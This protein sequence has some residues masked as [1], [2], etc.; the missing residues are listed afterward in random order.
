MLQSL[1]LAGPAVQFDAD[2]FGQAPGSAFWTRQ[3]GQFTVASRQRD[4][5]ADVTA[6]MHVVDAPRPAQLWLHVGDVGDSKLVRLANTIGYMRARHVSQGNAQFLH[7]LT[8]QL[9]VPPERAMEVAQR[10]INARLVSP[11]GGQYELQ[12]RAGEF[13]T[14][15]ATGLPARSLQRNSGGGLLGGSG[16]GLLGGPGGGLLGG[17]GSGLLAALSPPAGFQT[18]PLDWF[19]G[20]NLDF[21][22]TA[23]KIAAHA[24][25]DMQ[26]PNLDPTAAA[27][28]PDRQATR[29]AT[30]PPPAPESDS[31]APQ[32]ELKSVL[33]PGKGR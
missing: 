19:R 3:T 16:G 17:G 11:V 1:G 20:L 31:A 7:L 30:P 21:G 33:K 26:R 12:T 14:W 15:A 32:P 10:L 9:G 8:T 13:P 18:P 23:G 25:L 24:E 4:L 27:K 6:D 2:G 5:L 28:P 22:A 29:P